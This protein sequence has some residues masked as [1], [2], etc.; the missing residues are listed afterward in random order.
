MRIQAIT[1]WQPWATLVALGEK[2]IE[3]R[4]WVASYRGPLAIHAAKK[5]D[6]ALLQLCDSSPYLGLLRKH[7]FGRFDDLPLGAVVAVVD[8]TWAGRSE[9]I[10]PRLQSNGDEQELLL[11]DYSPD[12]WGWYFENI[13]PLKRPVMATGAQGLWYW[14]VPV[15]LQRPLGLTVA[16]G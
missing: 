13:R 16:K 7:G 1:L 5:A 11:G 3:T 15:N 14:D 4:G 8:F 10:R 12:R 6:G 2:K 9:V